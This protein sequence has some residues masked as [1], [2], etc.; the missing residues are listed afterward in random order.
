MPSSLST[1]ATAI[2][3]KQV[4]V[5]LVTSAD[6]PPATIL[7][8]IDGE[9]AQGSITMLIGPSGSGKSTLLSLC[10]LLL[11]ANEG[12]VSVQGTLVH[13]WQINQLRRTVGMV[14]QDSPMLPG[15]VR[16]NLL[17]ASRLHQLP[18]D[19]PVQWLERVGLSS[20]LLERQASELSGGQKQRI[21]LIRTLIGQPAIV[22]LDEITSALDP[23]S[24][25]HIEQLL[26]QLN[27]DKGTT[28]VWVTHHL[29]QAR[30]I[31][32]YI[33]YLE[34]GRLVETGTADKMLSHPQTDAARQFL[35]STQENPTL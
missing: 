10:N 31:G 25:Q 26:L 11:T 34:N 3:F 9:I 24:V 7:Q 20:D 30:R 23:S 13:D 19:D 22:L 27:R 35:S 4:S 16:D 1:R 15:T 8:H 14:F 6:Q 12:E 17:T 28:L 33:W 5:H 21:A 18:V 29:E 32:Q 2:Q